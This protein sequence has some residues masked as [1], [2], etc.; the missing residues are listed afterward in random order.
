MRPPLSVLFFTAYYIS[1]VLSE[2]FSYNNS[3]VTD[4]IYSSCENTSMCCATNRTPGGENEPDICLP[5][6]VCYNA[7]TRNGDKYETWFR[8]FCSQSDWKTGNCLT[9]CLSTARFLEQGT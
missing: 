5:N 8:D 7:Q 4:T 9:I 1:F 2:C 6:G 3:L